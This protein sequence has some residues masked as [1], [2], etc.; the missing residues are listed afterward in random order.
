MQ[1]Q[2]FILKIFLYFIIPLLFLKHGLFARAIQNYWQR[3]GSSAFLNP[4]APCMAE[5]GRD[6][7]KSP[8]TPRTVAFIAPN[9]L[10][11]DMNT[12]RL[13]FGAGRYGRS[14]HTVSAAGPAS[15]LTL[16]EHLD[17]GI[18]LA[19]LISVESVTKPV[20]LP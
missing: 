10:R 16:K 9:V 15:S 12:A 18:K 7:K 11:I 17:I 20:Q 2:N 19:H 4:H 5:M 1:S 13:Q 8:F 14:P 3:A 6:A